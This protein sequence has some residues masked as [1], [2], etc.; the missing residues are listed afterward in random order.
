LEIKE[1]NTGKL[2]AASAFFMLYLSG[3]GGGGGA[4]PVISPA[5]TPTTKT[6][7]TG[8]AEKGP[9]VKGSSVSVYA[10]TGGAKG[11]LLLQT[12]TSD[13]SGNYSADLGSY[14][15]PVIVEAS[16]SYHDEATGNIVPVLASAPIRAALPNAQGNVSLPVTPLTELA[17]QNAGATLNTATITAAN[18][19]V[20]SIF[21]VDIIATFPV[22]PTSAAFATATQTQKDYTLALATVSQIASTSAGASGTD[23][24]QTALTALSQSISSTGM[25]PEATASFQT[26]LSDF[27][28]TNSNNQTGVS[29]T[30]ATSLV[31][32]GTYTKSYLLSL[33]GAFATG[34]VKGLKF[35]VAL[36]AG[37]TVNMDSAD[38][39]VL[40][41]SLA[42]SG[43]STSGALLLGRFSAG[44]VTIGIITTA[45][46]SAGQFATLTCNIPS[47]ATA[48]SAAA[49]T[50]KNLNA[51]DLN[52]DLMAQATVALN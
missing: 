12:T 2:F 11:A 49:F 4:G 43:G 33:Q 18:T 50:V 6:V 21:K 10:V 20:S 44:S 36:P 31:N 13:D 14:T 27:V 26:A 8:V 39:S 25:T 23:K 17:V 16:G 15:G 1:M 30:S 40:S 42:L 28:T 7:V 38:S 35:D 32:V 51:I 47:G 45:G 41:S 34:A 19:L 29:S 52:G 9:F 24:L 5:P 3:C 37:V 22:A 46:F 48:P